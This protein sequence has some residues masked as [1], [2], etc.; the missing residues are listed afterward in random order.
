MV[1]RD[2]KVLRCVFFLDIVHIGVTSVYIRSFFHRFPSVIIVS[3]V[4]GSTAT[5]A[6]NEG[7]PMGPKTV[8]T[9][10]D[11]EGNKYMCDFLAMLLFV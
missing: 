3:L 1:S 6:A 9:D 5:I 10:I 8:S 11:Q 2:T 7:V 4:G